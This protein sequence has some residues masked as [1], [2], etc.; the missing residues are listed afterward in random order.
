[1]ST[2]SV[3]ELV[4]AFGMSGI[5]TS[6]ASR[7]CEE[8]EERVKV[9][10]ERPLEGDWLHLWIDATYVKV[11]QA[12]RIVSVA[13]I[14]AVAVNTHGRSEDVRSRKS[15]PPKQSEL[16]CAGTTGY[17]LARTAQWRVGG[18]SRSMVNA[19]APRRARRRC[20]R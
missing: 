4:K 6:Q 17:S 1:V 20:R 12:G 13:L 7:L 14:I 15:S 3:D 18:A 11:R 8:M 19:A 2:R 5:S 16:S 9:F 10:L